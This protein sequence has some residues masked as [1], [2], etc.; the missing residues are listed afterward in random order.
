MPADRLRLRRLMQAAEARLRQGQPADQLVSRLEA[1]LGKSTDRLA[2]RR[3]SVPAPQFPSDLPVVARKDDIAA[4]IRENQVV[5]IS[6]ETGSGKTTQLPKICLELGRGV[7]GVIG[8]TQP[9][10]IAARTVAARIADELGR[11]LGPHPGPVGYKVRFGDK[12][13]PDTFVKV[14]TDG[15]LLAE[16]QTDR[17]LEQYDTLI[18]DEAHERSLN[19]DFLLGYIRQLLPRRPDLKVII[20]SATIDPER[21]AKHFGN[22]RGPAPIIEVSGRTYPVETRYRPFA[23][24]KEDDRDQ[25]DAILDA[26]D[27]LATVGSGDVLVFLAGER[28]IRETA[29][30]LRKHHPPTT[31]VIP[32]YARLSATEQ[33]RV[34]Q[35]HPPTIR[36]IVLATNVAE[37]SLTVPGIRYVVDPGSARISRYSH[38]TKVQR[39]PIEPVSQASADQR[40]GRCGRVAE[41]VC[42]RLYSE[43]DFAARPRFTDPE[44]LRT[45]L[46][47]VILQMKALRL[48]NV[49]DFP[50]IEP[51]EE[52]MIHDGYETLHELGAIDEEN[53]LT[54][55]GH[56][57]A[58]LP[59]DPR[60]GRM[61]LQAREEKALPEV[62]VIAAALSLQDP[63]ERPMAQADLADVAHAKWRDENS[64]FV[65][66]LKLW[67]D[68]KEQSDHLSGSRLRKWCRDNFLSFIRTRE[69]EDIHQQL[70]SIAGDLGIMHRSDE[71]RDLSHLEPLFSGEQET[72]K[73]EVKDARVEKTPAYEAIHRSLLAGLLSNIGMRRDTPEYSGARTVKFNIFPGSGLFKKKPKWLMAAELVQTTKLY[74]RTCARIEAEWIESLAPHLIKKSHFDPHWSME[75]GQV[76]A[77]ERV[78]LFGLEIVARRRVHYGPINPRDSRKIF[79]HDALMEGHIRPATAAAWPFF[80]HNRQV[81]EGVRR[82]EAK[83]R[84]PDLVLEAQVI[85]DFYEARLPSGVYSVATLDQW[86]RD[87]E[88]KNPKALFMRPEDLM[89][90][91][92][93]GVTQ[94]RYPDTVFVGATTRLNLDYLL[95]PGGASDGITIEVPIEALLLLDADRAEWLVPGMLQDKIIALFRSL[96]KSYRKLLEP[97][98]ALAEQLAAGLEFGKGSLVEK[99]SAR[100]EALRGVKIPRES[101]QPRGIPDHLRMNVRVLDEKGKLLA[102]S[103]D[104]L[105]LKNRFGAKAQ[106]S[107]AKATRT[108]YD[109][110]GITSWDFGELPERVDVTRDGIKLSGYPALIDQG[111]SASLR[112]LEKADVAAAATRGGLKRLF[113]L[114]AKDEINY[115][116]RLLRNFDQMALHHASL[117]GADQLKRDLID[118]VAER[119]FLVD[120]PPVRSKA[121]FE[122]RLS[123]GWKQIGPSMREAGQ[124]VGQILSMRHALALRLAEKQP[125][126]W[127]L[128]IADLKDQL[129]R[130]LPKGFIGSTPYEQLRQFPRYLSAIAM[131]LEKLRNAG[132]QRDV[133]LMH[134]LMPLWRR[135]TTRANEGA[136]PGQPDDPELT[137]YRWMLEE[138][139]VSMFAQELGTAH[140]VSTKRL[141]EHWARVSPVK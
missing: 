83:V 55:L 59:I 34:F 117:G 80:E 103:R 132:L 47:S 141:E 140:P 64:D 120:R 4:A 75:A 104:I 45:N 91:A 67:K 15:I 30:A 93:E 96:P 21:F 3:A 11:A 138:L 26:I 98:P 94:E 27:E 139:R 119:V 97:M 20:T 81:I 115:Q 113:I 60:L 131:R 126:A 109:R 133:K 17:L 100:I 73:G 84:K 1:E 56:D 125:P 48:G 24:E 69:W 46:A 127:E 107:F 16:T 124:L 129:V 66:L 41:G 49:E 101:W 130:L 53:N 50:F 116:L 42:I 36:R 123:E 31:E 105:D 10:R 70:H 111:A 68:W 19:I 25:A 137:K 62:L 78:M 79:I 12:T 33:M 14:M 128:T 118:L 121:D 74:A 6:G 106:K 54:R 108:G 52:R 136:I 32:L 35:P 110:E 23:Q 87:A 99:L 77:F 95:D 2:R 114:Q 8:H 7:E 29:E 22:S 37:T 61:I 28:E 102:E 89:A 71:R 76:A 92:P 122:K 90:Q 72:S 86:R 57:L 18:I 135:W 51:P 39:L 88:R 13:G 44:I 134:E 85:H 9:R 65:S 58:R 5:V 82:I 43:E 63:R 112:M 40:K 38:R